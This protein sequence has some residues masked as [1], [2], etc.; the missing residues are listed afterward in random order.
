MTTRTAKP[1]LIEYNA[2]VVMCLICEEDLAVDGVRPAFAAQAE[3]MAKHGIEYR[4]CEPEKDGYASSKD[5][6][7]DGSY[8]CTSQLIIGEKDGQKRQ[9]MMHILAFGAFLAD[10][11]PAIESHSEALV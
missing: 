2:W 4:K 6:H 9:V 11:D 3:H 5:E 8:D 1:K 7:H 10:S